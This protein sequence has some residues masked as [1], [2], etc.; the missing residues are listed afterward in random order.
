MASYNKVIVVGNMTRDPELRYTPGG[1]AVCDIGIAVNEKYTDKSGQK[2]ENVHFFDITAWAKT[3]ELVSQY[4][5]KGSSILVEGK[6]SQERWDD[7]TT[8]KKMSKV[9]IVAER[10]QFLNSKGQGQGGQDNGGGQG[11]P[12]P[13]VTPDTEDIPF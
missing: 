5:R 2:V 8:G 12:E 1:A 6:L 3:A 9:K 7:K 4:C 10:V 11:A 13:L